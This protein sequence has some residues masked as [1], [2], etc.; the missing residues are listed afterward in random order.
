VSIGERLFLAMAFAGG[1]CIGWAFVAMVTELFVSAQCQAAG[2]VSGSVTVQF[3]RYCHKRI[4][5]SDVVIPLSEVLDLGR[6]P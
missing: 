6:Q 4:N 2:Y 5:G 1:L 3:D